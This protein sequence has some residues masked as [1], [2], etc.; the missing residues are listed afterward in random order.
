[1]HLPTWPATALALIATL[2]AALASSALSAQPDGLH[3]LDGEWVYVDSPHI[4]YELSADGG[5]TASIGFAKGGRPQRF[6]FNR[7][8]P[9]K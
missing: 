8:T 3:A 7:E 9:G 2:G 6:E 1:M 4:T 5:L